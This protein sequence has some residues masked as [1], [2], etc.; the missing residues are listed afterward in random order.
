[1]VFDCCGVFIDHIGRIVP[2]NLEPPIRIELAA[3][4]LD[5]IRL[6][7]VESHLLALPLKVVAEHLLLSGLLLAED[8]LPESLGLLIQQS[9]VP[10]VLNGLEG[11]V[12]V[13]LLHR[14]GD[15][16]TK[17]ANCLGARIASYHVLCFEFF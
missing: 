8:L 4:K 3:E 7:A 1:M 13:Q 15:M 10:F 12:H 6:H 5:R 9:G 11:Y 16:F 17:D 2:A 14:L